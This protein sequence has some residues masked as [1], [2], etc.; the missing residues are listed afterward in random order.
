MEV[1]ADWMM[2]EN[3]SAPAGAGA[4]LYWRRVRVRRCLGGRRGCGGRFLD[5]GYRIT[6]A[7]G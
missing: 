6:Y 2:G 7:T 3:I 5:R 4:E 1:R